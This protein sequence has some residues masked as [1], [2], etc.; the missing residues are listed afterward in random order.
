MGHRLGGSECADA[1]VSR[2]A[3]SGPACLQGGALSQNVVT[4]RS[5]VN[6][7]GIVRARPVTAQHN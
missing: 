2:P 5:S 6:R 3:L 1:P 4:Q 7:D